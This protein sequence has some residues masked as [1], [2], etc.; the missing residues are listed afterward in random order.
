M[1]NKLCHQI[2][3]QKRRISLRITELQS[4]IDKVNEQIKTLIPQITSSDDDAF[5]QI[6]RLQRVREI[7]AEQ[8]EQMHQV[9]RN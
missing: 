6:R 1:D 7:M 5:I 8:L 4:E 2:D 9:L 3:E